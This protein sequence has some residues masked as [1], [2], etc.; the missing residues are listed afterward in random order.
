MLLSSDQVLRRRVTHPRGLMRVGH[1]T[2][3]VTQRGGGYS[4][5][6]HLISSAFPFRC[7]HVFPRF[8]AEVDLV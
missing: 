2:G 1:L 8:L 4:W 7:Q 5:R 3:S 6:P